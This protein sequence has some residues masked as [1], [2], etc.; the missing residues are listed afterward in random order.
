[1]LIFISSLAICN[2]WLFH[3]FMTFTDMLA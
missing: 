3:F 2:S 1:L